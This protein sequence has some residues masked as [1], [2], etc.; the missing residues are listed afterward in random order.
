M[1][2]NKL[3]INTKIRITVL[4][5]RIASGKDRAAKV[6]EMAQTS[7]KVEFA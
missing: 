2:N 4:K 3:D 1:Q 7:T 6:F 5:L